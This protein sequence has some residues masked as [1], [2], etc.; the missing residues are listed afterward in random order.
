MPVIISGVIPVNLSQLHDVSIASP[1]AGQ[2]LRYSGSIWQN[3]YLNSDVFNY[4]NTSL[5]STNGVTLDFSIPNN[6]NIGLATVNH[7]AGTFGSASDIPVFTVDSQGRITSITTAASSGAASATILSTARYISAYGDADW[8]VLFDGSTDVDSVITLATVNA[9]PQTDTFCKITVNDKGLVT[10]T[11]A[12]TAADIEASLTFTPLNVAGDTM[13]GDLLLNADPTLPLGAVTKQYADAIAAGV[14]V[15]A[16]CETATNALLNIN[17]NNGAAGVGATIT[18]AVN[19]AIGTIGGYGSLIVGSRILVKDQVETAIENGIYIVTDLGSPTTPWVLTRADDFDGSPTFEIQAGDLTYISEGIYTGTQWV[20]TSTGSGMPGDYIVIGSDPI[21]FTQ[22]SGPSTYIAGTGI[23]IATTT[24]SN[25]GVTSLIAGT[26]VSLSG[27][28]G[29]ITIS[30]TG[31]VPS[32]T[33]STNIS[34]GSAGSIPYQS[35]P[36]TTAM[37]AAGTG[38]LVGGAIPSYS[39]TPALTG[40]NFSG[41]AASLNIGGNAG[42]VTN[43]LYTTG[44]NTITNTMLAGS[45]ANAKLANSSITVGSTTISLGTT[46]ATLSGLTSVSATT[47]TGSGSGLTS[48]PNS[49]LTGSGSITLGSTAMAL[50]SAIFNINGLTSVTAT[51]FNGSLSGTASSATNIVGGATGS[52][53]YQSAANVTAMLAAGTNG[54]VLTLAAG[55]PTWAA[56]AGGSLTVSDDTTTNATY[57]PTLATVTSGT[58]SVEKVSSTKLGFNPLHGVLSVG[59]TPY[60]WSGVNSLDIGGMSGY[61]ASSNATILATNSYYNGSTWAAKTTNTGGMYSINYTGVHTWSSIASTLAG[62]GQILTQTMSLDD[63]GNLIASGNVTAYSDPRLKENIRP[64]IGAVELLSN[65]DGVYFDWKRGIPQTEV[66]AGKQDI[67]IL[68]DQVEAV[69]P[70]IVTH[71]VE[72]AG[73]S[74]KTVAYDKLV[75]VLIEAIKE[76]SAAN[77]D[78]LARIQA[79]E[80]K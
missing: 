8:A 58:V 36:N 12:V 22:F 11:S 6:I 17:Y 61:A 71:S 32:S 51:T 54:N 38:V 19:G 44:V 49:A 72:I 55:V 26:N 23:S 60:A 42:T 24:I 34:G 39:T 16:S 7:T 20:Q 13:L 80:L 41:T 63:V 62:S 31:T 9:S 33:T 52:I 27:S 45:I 10:A 40:T 5:T 47:F 25:T 43:G 3:S 68:A 76:L 73:Q 79:L 15:H 53:P 75:P 57:Y 74:Y 78:L 65:I 1:L 66:K 56:A 70:E 69:F 59:T 21:D 14:N 4:L 30:T 46:T 35:A 77:K 67:G 37:L 29:A 48:I 2:Y 64:I 28:T 50:G 18:S